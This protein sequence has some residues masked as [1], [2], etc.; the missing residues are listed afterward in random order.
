MQNQAESLPYLKSLKELSDIFGLSYSKIKRLVNER[1]KNGL[2]DF[3]Y[4]LRS[5]K[6]N[7]K[8]YLDVHKFAQWLEKQK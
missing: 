1:E 2:A 3:T 5:T 4:Q 6:A 7:C 8:L